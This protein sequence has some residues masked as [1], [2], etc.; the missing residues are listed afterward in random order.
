M[1]ASHYTPGGVLPPSALQEVVVRALMQL[2]MNLR[3]GKC[4][5]D[6]KVLSTRTAIIPIS[7][8]PA[9]RRNMRQKQPSVFEKD[10]RKVHLSRGG[11]DRRTPRSDGHIP[12]KYGNGTKSPCLEEPLCQ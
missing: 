6:C 2:I 7:R 5:G 11:I 3:S 12:T 4:I 10:D 9:D 8:P 1:T